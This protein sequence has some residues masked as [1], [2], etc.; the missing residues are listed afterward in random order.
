MISDT[1][2]EEVLSEVREYI[3]FLYQVS[4]TISLL[5]VITALA[6]VSSGADYTKVNQIMSLL[7]FI[8]A[9]AT[10]S[11]GA[12]YTK[13]SQIISLLDVITALATVSSGAD[14]SKVSQVITYIFTRCYYSFGNCVLWCRLYQG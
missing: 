1:I 6:T 14:Y 9:L 11:S 8:T 10:V 7:D 4:E 2:L 3:W 12:D 5:D 13:V